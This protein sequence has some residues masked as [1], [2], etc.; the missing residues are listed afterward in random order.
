MGGN[1]IRTFPDVK[2][3]KASDIFGLWEVLRICDGKGKASYPW[4]KG[5]FKFN[6]M[7]EMIFMVL[8]EGQ[9]HHGN[10]K[11]A[12]KYFETKKLFSII[13]NDTFEYMIIEIGED[14]L[15]MSDHS[16]EYLLVRRL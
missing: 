3:I 8:K 6:F 10:W 7:E 1:S 14:E 15:L 13:L 11:L 9:C 5:R 16:C 2:N 4:L 12:E